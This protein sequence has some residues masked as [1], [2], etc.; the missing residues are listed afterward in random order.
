MNNAAQRKKKKKYGKIVG[1]ATL[2]VL[3]LALLLVYRALIEQQNDPPADTGAADTDVIML[4]NRKASEISALTYS[5]GETEYG[6]TC[7]S[8]TGQWSLA[9][10]PDFPLDQTP[11][12][13][14]AAAVAAIGVYRDLG[15]DSGVYGFDAPVLTVS[16]TYIDGA[17]HHYAVGDLNSATGNRYLKDVDTGL[18]YTVSPSLLDYFTYTLEDMLLFDTLP[19]DIDT[20][21]ITAVTLN[22]GGD[23]KAIT[24]EVGVTELYGLFTTLAPSE[25][26]D[27]Y[28]DEDEK[29][30]YGIGSLTMTIDY[31][32]IA[33]VADESSATSASRVPASYTVRFGDTTEDGKVYYTLGKSDIVYLIYAEQVDKILGYLNYTPAETEAAE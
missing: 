12:A 20:D 4:I 7:H 28:A 18:V 19:T 29:A 13:T 26:A 16:V 33:A 8:T 21:Y 23:E 30:A 14:M 3:V 5:R 22:A 24:D 25:Y 32:R 1:L 9:G 6:F 15:E 2:I 17:V 31:K 27:W 10:E 11:V